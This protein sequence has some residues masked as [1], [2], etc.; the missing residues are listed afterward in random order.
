MHYINCEHI[1]Y[2]MCIFKLDHL[3]AEKSGCSIS[4]TPQC[5]IVGLLGVILF[6]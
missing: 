5:F 4:L 1:K 2:K 3:L 6:Y